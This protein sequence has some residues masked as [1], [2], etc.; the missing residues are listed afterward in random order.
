ME[1]RTLHYFVTVAQ[2]G[3]VS[4]AASQLHMT[5]PALSRQIRQLEHELGVELFVR[6]SGR[7]VLSAAGRAFLPHALDVLDRAR[8]ARA[9]ANATASGRLET[10][11]I[12]APA[13]TI[14]DVIAP[15]VATLSPTDPTPQVTEADPLTTRGEV[16]QD[17]DLVILPHTAPHTAA[18]EPIA[19]LP[20][21]AYV[22]LGHAWSSRRR[23]DITE[24]AEQTVLALTLGNTPRQI[25]DDALVR[26]G[27]SPGAMREC[28]HPQ[29]AQ[30]LAAADRGVAVLS[31][32]PRFGL[33]A[34]MIDTEDG[35]LQIQLV[36]AWD[37]SHHAGEALR[38]MACR[39]RAFC[40]ERY[41]AD[42]VR[43]PEAAPDTS[44]S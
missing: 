16:D 3:T 41:G 22:P 20:L 8:I 5:Q 27:V 13:T 18:S 40:G 42:A 34:V 37:R 11:T 32:D 19:V 7:L 33:H 26:S 28:A 24:L 44:G 23:I 43:F 36:A 9:A 29:I 10:I 39:L 17:T 21:W 35:P 25:L 30:A 6:T 31:D 12:R 4:M 38:H 14:N 15:F 1:L 2:A